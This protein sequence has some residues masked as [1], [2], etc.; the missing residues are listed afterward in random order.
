VNYWIFATSDNAVPFYNAEDAYRIRMAYRL[1]GAG[2]NV[3]N[4]RNLRKGDKVVFYLA[5]PVMAFVGTATIA[6]TDISATE[7]NRMCTS[8]VFSVGDGVRLTDIDTWS[9]ARGIRP[10]VEDLSFI[11]DK[12]NWGAFIRGAITRIPEYDFE[13]ITE[14]EG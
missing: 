11:R 13:L 1:W 3:R 5:S 4:R 6:S 7:V 12:D 2:P 9:E 10:L 14:L 8:S